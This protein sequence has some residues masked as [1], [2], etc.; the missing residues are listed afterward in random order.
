MGDDAIDIPAVHRHFSTRCFNDAW[1]IID[2]ESRSDADVVRMLNL[3]HASCW[4]WSQR[5]DCTDRHRSIAYWQLSRVYAL[6]G[7]GDAAMYFAKE[8]RAVSE[9]LDA[10]LRGF[11]HEAIARAALVTGD[12]ATAHGHVLQAQ[13]LCLALLDAEERGSLFGA[14]DDILLRMG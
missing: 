10:F 14:I 8:C 11:S 4:H 9:G 7:F 3:A 5:D 12:R 1:K 6:A 13:A 2:D